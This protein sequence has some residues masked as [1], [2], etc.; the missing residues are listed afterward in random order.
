MMPYLFPNFNFQLVLQFSTHTPRDTRLWIRCEVNLYLLPGAAR[1]SS[2][3]RAVN[4]K[5]F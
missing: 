3:Q 4:Y 2:Q 1:A 5:V